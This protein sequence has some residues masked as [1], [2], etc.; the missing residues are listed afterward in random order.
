MGEFDVNKFLAGMFIEHPPAP[1]TPAAPAPVQPMPTTTGGG[2]PAAPAITP[3]SGKPGDGQPD[4]IPAACRACAVQRSW[5]ECLGG[6]CCEDCTKDLS[7]R[8]SKDPQ[9]NCSEGFRGDARDQVGKAFGVSG[10]PHSPERWLAQQDWSQWAY[11]AGRWIGPDADAGGDWNSLPDPAPCQTCGSILAW[12]NCWGE[13]R[14]EVCEPRR[15]WSV[16]LANRA[17]M[18]QRRDP[19]KPAAV[20]KQNLTN[21]TEI[22]RIPEANERT[23]HQKRP[24]T[25]EGGELGSMEAT[26]RS[27]IPSLA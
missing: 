10:G 4:E 11:R 1:T 23:N 22:S 24:R 27:T 14:C 9:N 17:A 8:P 18:L 6:A 26:L 21:T 15:Q 3:D 2:W 20:A 5:F 25:R 13:R 16:A 19:P 12:W 7:G